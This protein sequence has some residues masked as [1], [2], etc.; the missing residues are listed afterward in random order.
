MV[1][2]VLPPGAVYHPAGITAYDVTVRG[3]NDD[4]V[5]A[6]V[7][8]PSEGGPHPGLLLVHGIHGYEEHMKDMARRYAALGYAAIVPALYSRDGFLTVV[9]AFRHGH[10]P[11]DALNARP[12]V[13]TVD[14]LQGG[15]DF[16]RASPHVSERIGVVGFCSGGR[17]GLMFASSGAFRLTC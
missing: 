11:G 9:E 15:L 4:P 10:R 13:Q 14:D 1:N 12:Y 6:Y 16:L 5:P 2:Q 7:A 8:R 17:L 3:Y